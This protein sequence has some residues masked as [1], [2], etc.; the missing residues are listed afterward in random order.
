MGPAPN[1]VGPTWGSATVASRRSAICPRPRRVQRIDATGLVVAPGFID[2]H[3]HIDAQAFWDTTLS[4]SPLHGVTTAIAGNCGF[5]VAAAVR[6]SERRRVPDA[7]AQPRRGDAAAVVA[8]GRAVELDLHR[9]VP[10]PARPHPVDQHG[11]Q[12]RSLRAAPRRDGRRRHQAHGDP[13]RGRRDV[14]PAAR[15]S[16]G[17][18]DRVL[19]V[20]VVH[21][22]RHRA[23]H[24]A[25]PLRRP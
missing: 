9:R 8:A 15:R 23:E 5:S 20:V 7:D 4:P 16:G 18:R 2:V 6:R 17:R 22:Q 13:R 21:P 25:E 1:G 12:G 19:V 3:T 10:R 11:V 14:R 24:G